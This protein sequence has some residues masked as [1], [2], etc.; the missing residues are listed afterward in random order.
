MNLKRVLAAFGWLCFL[1]VVFLFG[2]F[3]GLQL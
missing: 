3:T 1:V 2:Y